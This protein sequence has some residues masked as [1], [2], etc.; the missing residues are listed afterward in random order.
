MTTVFELTTD[1]AQVEV[2]ALIT[3][4]LHHY[5]S[6]RRVG[7]QTLYKLTNL[8]LLL[9]KFEDQIEIQTIFFVSFVESDY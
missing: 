4:R 3:I 5:A 7:T 9:M 2:A 8:Q 1:G 6:V